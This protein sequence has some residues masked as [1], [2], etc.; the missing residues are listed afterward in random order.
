MATLTEAVDKYI[1]NLDQTA[2][3]GEPGDIR[4]M[5]ESILEK[6]NDK[7]VNGK[8]YKLKNAD[9]IEIRKSGKLNSTFIDACTDFINDYKGNKGDAYK[10]IK[11]FIEFINIKYEIKLDINEVFSEPIYSNDIE[12]KLILLKKLQGESAVSLRQLEDAF[13]FQTKYLKKDLNEIA[14]EGI[15]FMGQKIK[16][17]TEFDNN[18]KQ[19]YFSTVYPIFLP[20]N[21]HEIYCLTVG[22][23]EE[24]ENSP[25]KPVFNKIAD[26]IYTQLSEYGK[27]VINKSLEQENNKDIYFNTNHNIS[28]K[29]IDQCKQ[30]IHQALILF[31]KNGM[32]GM[33]TL[34][35][36]K[37]LAFAHLRLCINSNS[38]VILNLG[39]DLIKVD[40]Q[41][42]SKIEGNGYKFPW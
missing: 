14:T 33:I 1:E 22:L 21:M 25:Y 26:C 3:K 2:K 23:K 27:C 4:K 20:L 12:R 40:I 41:N 17:S 10:K 19:S 28:E 13:P 31:E 29:D 35:D 38:G 32:D 16:I 18:N 15:D 39:K 9:L 37:I 8:T 11:D 5:F 42:I 34:K 36:G 24:E 30:S 7:I 6:A